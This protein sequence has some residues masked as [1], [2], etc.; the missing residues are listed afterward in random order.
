MPKLSKKLCLIQE[1]LSHR[2]TEEHHTEYTR[3]YNDHVEVLKQKSFYV[4][5]DRRDRGCTKMFT[6]LEAAHKHIVQR[7]V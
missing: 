4:V 3:F 6:S 1:I 7:H 5:M 2:F